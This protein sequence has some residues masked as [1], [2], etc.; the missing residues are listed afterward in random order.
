MVRI[1]ILLPYL[2]D[3]H[4]LTHLAIGSSLVFDPLAAKMVSLD[5]PLL[6]A[7]HAG[8]IA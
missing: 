5:E 1:M 3:Q 7:G 4:A 6:K 2:F 8:R